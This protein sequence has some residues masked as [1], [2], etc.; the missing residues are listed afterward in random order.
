[1]TSTRARLAGTLVA[2]GLAAGWWTFH[3]PCRIADLYRAIPPQATLIVESPRLGARGPSLLRHPLLRGLLV[4]GGIAESRLDA[5]QDSRKFVRLLRLVGRRHTVVAQVPDFTGLDAGEADIAW[6]GASWV[7][8]WNQPLRWGLLR[9]IMGSKARSLPMGAGRVIW[10]KPV[11]RPGSPSSFVSACVVDGVLVACLSRDPFGVRHLVHR[12][13][14]RVEPPAAL[15][16]E[17][18]R[19][20]GDRTDRVWWRLEDPE[21]DEFRGIRCVLDTSHPEA[22][23]AQIAWL[24]GDARTPVP[25]PAFPSSE[26]EGADRLA[27]PGAS[28]VVLTSRRALFQAMEALDWKTWRRALNRLDAVCE[29]NAP[30]FAALYWGDRGGRIVGLRV[31]S[32]LLGVRTKTASVDLPG[33][34][35]GTLDAV[36]A[37]GRTTLIPRAVSTN[38]HTHIVVESGRP[39]IHGSLR[40]GEEP[41]VGVRDGWL[42]FASNAR[43][44][45]R[46]LGSP[47]GPTDGASRWR[48]RNGEHPPAP[49]ALWANLPE[50]SEALRN[51]IAAYELWLMTEDPPDLQA[52][53]ERLRHV[54]LGL[55]RA[56]VFRELTAWGSV[57]GPSP[58]MN[59]RLDGLTPTPPGAI[60]PTE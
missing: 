22:A 27:G 25:P 9:R 6:V 49:L 15:A 4:A 42:L 59:L 60:P 50:A 41:A 44:M 32:L 8:A 47:P 2:L 17:P 46:V 37:A 29:T 56:A 1:M 57:Q 40:S 45:G 53:R 54:K 19:A 20:G 24:P 30:A 39:G 16:A 48:A 5:L 38:G 3:F 33:L 31:P 43:T 58:R 18:R 35:S 28:L 26:V 10:F 11:N 52:T 36:N 23:D 12:L 51:A 7:G 14:S 21:G 34:A 13:D 55:Q